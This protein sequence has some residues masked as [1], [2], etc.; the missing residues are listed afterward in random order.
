[1]SGGVPYLPHGTLFSW[2][3]SSCITGGRAEHQ[4]R[5]SLQAASGVARRSCTDAAH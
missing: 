3:V 4:S 2:V 1:M 5:Q